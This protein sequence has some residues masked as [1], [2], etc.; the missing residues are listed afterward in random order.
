MPGLVRTA[1][2]Q[3]PGARAA[4]RRTSAY[5]AAEILGWIACGLPT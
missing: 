5:D 1:R 4:L 2:R 3:G